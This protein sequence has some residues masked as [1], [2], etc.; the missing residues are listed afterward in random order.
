MQI[1]ALEVGMVRQ[2]GNRQ[3]ETNVPGRAGF[4]RTNALYTAHPA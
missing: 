4:F 1:K 2:I 3:E